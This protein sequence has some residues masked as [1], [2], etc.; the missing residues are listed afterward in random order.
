MVA[1]AFGFFTFRFRTGGSRSRQRVSLSGVGVESRVLRARVVL[2]ALLALALFA[3]SAH[4]IPILHEPIPPDTR[5]DLA[6]GVALDGNLPAAVETPS[7]LV[8]A[9]DPRRPLGRDE[10]LGRFA[11]LQG[12]TFDTAA[13]SRYVPDTDT[14]RPDTLPYDEPFKPSTAPFKRLVAFDAVDSAYRLVV[15]DPSLNPLAANDAV[16]G[17]GTEEQFF[18]DLVVSPSS[19]HRVRIPSAGPGARIVHARFGS[20]PTDIGFKLWQD[21]AE[22]W[23]IEAN[24]PG[25]LVIELTVPRAA[26][27]GEFGDPHQSDLHAPLP[28]PNVLR[29]ANRVAAAIGVGRTSP[30]D[31]VKSLVAYFRSFT[32]SSER[33]AGKG[34]A[35]LDLAL[36]RK[37]VCRHRAYA[38]TITALALGIPARMVMNEAHAWVEVFDGSLWRRIDLGG[39]G[40]TLL[41]SKE[42]SEVPY[43]PPPDPFA[44]PPDAE[45][46]GDLARRAGP[47]PAAP[48]APSA[49]ESEVDPGAPA[50][51]TSTTPA[52][53]IAPHPPASVTGYPEGR[54]AATVTLE[55]VE[56]DARR[57]EPLHV[58]GQV[59]TGADPCPRALVLFE[60]RDARAGA[61]VSLG[62]LATDDAGAFSG[63]LVVPRGTAVGDYE[64]IAHTP[65]GPGCP[66]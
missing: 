32:D 40:R 63:V 8:A 50:S 60:L 64:V 26:F 31:T 17:D 24:E 62:A 39:A 49:R 15:R 7:G 25:R 57:S 27:G 16:R 47:G 51:T 65:G 53:R 14:R 20:G 3:D 21:S 45:R 1:R 12:H 42:A 4:A 55:V 44:W 52:A 58:H 28:P 30:R 48:G 19:G 5:D 54:S 29:D 33:P 23:F 10:A 66:E 6:L 18:A 22:N 13:A 9:P 37:G 43:A 46:G 11:T 59:R 56:T 61:R 38:F 36:S 2:G 34:N 41:N 35:Y